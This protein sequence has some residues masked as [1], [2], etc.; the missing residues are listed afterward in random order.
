MT[1]QIHSFQLI[2]NEFH[3]KILKY[4]IRL[5]DDKVEAE[6]LTQDVFVKVNNSLKKFEGRSS[7]STWIYKIATNVANDRFRSASFQKGKKQTLTGEFKEDN[8]EDRDL[9]ADSSVA[10]PDKEIA[11]NEMDSCIHR[12]IEGLKEEYKTVLVLSK[13]EELKNN[14]IAKVLGISTDTVK[15]RLYRAR[16]QLKKKIDSG[17][18]VTNDEDTGLFCD[19]K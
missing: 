12:Y 16:T 17:C 4:L 13:Y 18:D 8:K 3:P 19:E 15:I 1:S 9:W 14:E 6:D 7:L 2:Y 10:S 11:K 5:F